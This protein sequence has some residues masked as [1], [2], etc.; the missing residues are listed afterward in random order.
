MHEFIQIELIYASTIS[1]D[2]VSRDYHRQSNH[3]VSKF[4]I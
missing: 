3:P 2:E 4:N 1:I